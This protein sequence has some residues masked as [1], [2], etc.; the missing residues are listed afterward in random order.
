[1]A[2]K[3]FTV[4]TLGCKV[5]RTQ[6]DALAAALRAQ[7]A[8]PSHLST[9]ELV[10]VNTCTVTAEADAKSRKA[11]RRAAG[12][13]LQPWVIVT[14][15]GAALDCAQF[16]DSGERV[17]LI[18]N[19][20]LARDKALELLGIAGTRNERP[21]RFGRG[22]RTRVTLL[23]QDGCDNACSYCV[24]PLVRGCAQSVPPSRVVS[25]LKQA[26]QAGAREIVL[27]GIDLGAY[28]AE[29]LS[30]VG[31]I[32]RLLAE[33][34]D[35]RIRLSSVELRSLD[36]GVLELMAGSNGRLCAHLHIPLQSGSDRILAAMRRNYR[37]QDYLERIAQA[38]KL[39]NNLAITSDCIVGFPGETDDDFDQTRAACIQ[40][41]FSRIHVFRYSKRPH[42]AAA[43]LPGHLDGA[44]L[45]ARSANLR[46]LAAR[47]KS[48]DA[49]QRVGT[50]EQLLIERPGIGRSE[51]YHLVE[52]ADAPAV[53][54]LC[55]AQLFDF[56]NG[57][58]LGRRIPTSAT[59]RC[60]VV[61]DC[62]LKPAG[63]R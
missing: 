49:L 5:N 48:D 10:I 31:L 3:R 23:A 22:F 19:R 9:A 18:P 60:A 38:K 24:V 34:D 30:L 14:G 59:P 63:V 42:T 33:G 12:S 51:S 35:F 62:L 17:L 32:A 16:A 20:D 61:E 52:V 15:C 28:S 37:V 39:L 27:A 43:R 58:L 6:S 57:K 41:G 36:D 40:A 53:G 29:G 45:V 1:M 46:Q 8:E 4:I 26:R 13:S 47:L 7:G 25:Q 55:A 21:N 50:V 44:T 2:A 54:A 56:K 11:I